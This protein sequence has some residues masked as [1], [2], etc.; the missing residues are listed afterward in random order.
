MPR[1]QAHKGG[2]HPADIVA[3]VRKKGSSLVGIAGDLGLT[4]SAGSRALIIPH[5]RVNLAIAAMIGVSPHLLWPQWFDADGRRIRARSPRPR[6][7][8]TTRVSE[9]IPTASAPSKT[10]A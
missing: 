8:P 2:W 6:I 7:S 4:S 3:A 1:E 9:S 5:T 10:A